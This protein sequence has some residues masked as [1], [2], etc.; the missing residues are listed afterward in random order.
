MNGDRSVDGGYANY[1]RAGSEFHPLVLIVPGLAAFGTDAGSALKRTVPLGFQEDSRFVAGR[2]TQRH[3]PIRGMSFDA[4]TVPGIAGKRKSD[5]AVFGLNVLLATIVF[6]R[7]RAILRGKIKFAGA[8]YDRNRAILGAHSEIAVDASERYGTVMDL[9]V[10]GRG[11]GGANKQV[12]SPAL[13]GRRSRDTK[14]TI[15]ERQVHLREYGFGIGP[16]FSALQRV[17]E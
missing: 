6:Q 8:A 10:E 17:T 7:D 5:R 16:G 13:V 15:L 1:R 14:E 11:F 9:E 12:R 3:W 2:N 4:G